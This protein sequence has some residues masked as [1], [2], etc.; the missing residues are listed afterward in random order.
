MDW[1]LWLRH[2]KSSITLKSEY[3]VKV[4]DALDSQFNTLGHKI[5]NNFSFLGERT[6]SFLNWRHKYPINQKNLFFLV[7]KKDDLVGY[8]SY[9]LSNKK[10]QVK[11]I[12]YDSE[13]ANLQKILSLFTEYHYNE[14]TSSIAIAMSGH[15]QV[16]K[17]LKSNG[18]ILRETDMNYVAYSS[19][20]DTHLADNLKKQSWYL[21][22]ID[23]DT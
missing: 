18:F 9:H 3:K 23:N 17:E 1:L 13:T 4:T 14:K 20:P 12:A 7:H 10:C 16:I 22:L 11:D 21:T 5:Q 8:V 15:D 2:K 6:S 19:L